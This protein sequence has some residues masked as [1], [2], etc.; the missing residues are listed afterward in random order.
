MEGMIIQ[1]PAGRITLEV[2]RP[3]FHPR[4][5]WVEHGEHFKRRAWLPID[6]WVEPS[7]L[8]IQEYIYVHQQDSATSLNNVT[9]TSYPPSNM[10]FLLLTARVSPFDKETAAAKQVFRFLHR[11]G[12]DTIMEIASWC[13]EHVPR[14]GA[15]YVTLTHHICFLGRNLHWARHKGIPYW[16]N[17]NS[18]DRL[19]SEDF[20]WGKELCKFVCLTKA[21]SCQWMRHLGAFVLCRGHCRFTLCHWQDRNSVLKCSKTVPC[22]MGETTWNNWFFIDFQLSQVWMQEEDVAGVRWGHRCQSGQGPR[23]GGAI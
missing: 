10:I 9:G 17:S 16:H 5:F 22:P 21:N 14:K 20:C 11:A 18:L 7:E 4:S 1:H 19:Q 2:W 6:S 15:L 23:M 12:T 13:R 8:H 3:S